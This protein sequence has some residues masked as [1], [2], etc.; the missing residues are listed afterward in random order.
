ME[1]VPY[2]CDCGETRVELE[3][4]LSGLWLV[5]P[6]CEARRQVTELKVEGYND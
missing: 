5:C 6:T 3:N 2:K 1:L 4:R